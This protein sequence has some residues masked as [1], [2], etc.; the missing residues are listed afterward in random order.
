[1]FVVL[2]S[3]QAAQAAEATISA[4]E[5]KVRKGPEVGAEVIHVFVEEAT[6][7][8]AEEASAGWRRIRL[9]DGT[10]GWIEDGALRLSSAPVAAAPS[11]ARF[12]PPELARP[13]V[14]VKNLEHLTQI[15]ASD[16]VIHREAK[17]L[18]E[19]STVAKVVGYG[20]AALGLGLIL[21][22]PS[23]QDGCSRDVD[24]EF[25]CADANLAPLIGGAVLAVG[26]VIAGQMI[27]PD[28]EELLDLINHWNRRHVDQPF[29][30]R[31]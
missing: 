18:A 13:K 14:Y 21:L 23:L 24:G 9:P 2:A 27:A 3:A 5:G 8:V 29:E 15:V 12:V 30:I 31:D 26:A 7:S 25:R 22:T 19:R 10:T 28:R 11:V 20:G 6:V 1:V 17:A 4:F 16:G